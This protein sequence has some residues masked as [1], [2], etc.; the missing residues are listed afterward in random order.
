MKYIPVLI[1]FLFAI[2]TKAQ[3]FGFAIDHQSLIVNDLKKT[4][5]F[6]AKGR[7]LKEIP[8]PTND[9]GFRWFQVQGN[10][11]LHLILKDTVVMK[12]HKSMHLCLSTQKLGAF[13]ENLNKN[14]PHKFNLQFSYFEPDEE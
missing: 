4:G 6:Y 11:Q 2:T 13:I 3:T 14:N 7:Q 10:T 5:D 8:H 1:L 9:P 12:K